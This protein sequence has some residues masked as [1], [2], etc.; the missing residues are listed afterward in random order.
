MTGAR[1]RAMDTESR[2]RVRALVNVRCRPSSFLSS[3]LPPPCMSFF[4][5][6]QVCV[7]LWS[8]PQYCSQAWGGR[9]GPPC[10]FPPLGFR[11]T[12]A[13]IAR[14]GSPHPPRPAALTPLPPPPLSCDAD[15]P[16]P[17]ASWAL[18]QLAKAPTSCQGHL[19]KINGAAGALREGGAGKQGVCVLGGGEVGELGGGGRGMGRPGRDI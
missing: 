2:N 18:I 15:Q 7:R 12:K 11:I 10:E 13:P 8:I 5:S 1:H 4:Q 6:G 3:P 9:S 17:P 19:Y 14:A 16:P